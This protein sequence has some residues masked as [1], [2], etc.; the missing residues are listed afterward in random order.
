MGRGRPLAVSQSL[1]VRSKLAVRTERDRGHAKSM[2][3]KAAE[4]LTSLRVPD[5]HAV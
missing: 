1:T 3:G 5:L 2:S 4:V